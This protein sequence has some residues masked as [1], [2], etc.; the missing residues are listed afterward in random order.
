[1]A[2]HIFYWHEVRRVAAQW[3]GVALASVLA[4]V[5]MGTLIRE[6]FA[7]RLALKVSMSAGFT[8]AVVFWVLVERRFAVVGIRSANAFSPTAIQFQ[9]AA[10]ATAVLIVSVYTV[11]VPPAPQSFGGTANTCTPP[12]AL[13]VNAI[14]TF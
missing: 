10:F 5:L 7:D 3:I 9:T 4:G 12:I 14:S 1:M 13:G 8:L 2:K 11:Q 6:G